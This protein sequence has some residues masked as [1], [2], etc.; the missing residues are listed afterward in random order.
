MVRKINKQVTGGWLNTTLS[1]DSLLLIQS[2]EF[3]DKEEFIDN[4]GLMLGRAKMS[5][6]VRETTP[7]PNDDL[8]HLAKIDG[9]I[10]SLIENIDLVSL[11][12][13]AHLTYAWYKQGMSTLVDEELKNLLVKYQCSIL[14]AQSEIE[15]YSNQKGRK[16]KYIEH[17]LIFSIYKLITRHGI[18][19]FKHDKVCEIIADILQMNGI[20]APTDVKSITAIIQK[21]KK[22]EK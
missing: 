11:N 9:Q 5:I 2:L 15:R 12:A 6:E 18:T 4:L 21:F 7:S 19:R 10:S 8:A 3:K 22:N 14:Y 16:S 17:D 1:S 20:H 13:N